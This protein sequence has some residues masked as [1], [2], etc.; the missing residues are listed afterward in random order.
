M[1]P[2]PIL[3]LGDSPDLHTGLG[4]I[5]RDLAV[6]TSSLPEFRVG[7]LGRGG[8]G[9][10][11]FPIAQYTYCECG[12][13]GQ[14]NIEQV[15]ND[16]AGEEWGIIMSV[17][18]PSRLLWFVHPNGMPKNTIDFLQ[19]GRF[20]RW[21]YFAVDSVGVGGKLTTATRSTIAGYDRPLGYGMWGAQVISESI[22]REV[23]WMPHGMN[24]DRWVR[25]DRDAARMSMGFQKG[26]T[27][28]GMIATNQA[29][30][31]W[32]L[33][34]STIS[35]LRHRHKNLK[36]WLHTD[37]MSRSHAWNIDSL[38]HDFGLQDHVKVTLSG[39]FTDTQ[40][41]YAYTACD[42]TMLASTGEGF[43]YP[44]VESLACGT[45][46]VHGNYGGGAEL[47]PSANWLVEPQ[48]WRLEGIHNCVRPVYN[49]QDW[50]TTIE[51]VMDEKV[52][53]DF[54][55]QATS[56]LDWSIL[57]PACWQKWM[58]AGVPA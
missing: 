39:G 36:F 54:C 3:F 14:G 21:G 18:D 34:F 49:P 50:A 10:R 41:S 6:L 19:S 7:Y 43:G 27:W 26:E 29:R 24:L 45:P 2:T 5:G 13:W 47:V 23:D 56:H 11:K 4:R 1:K 58:K 48:A 16:F 51:R 12:Q 52:S 28:V 38:V 40:L 9:S 15:W 22:G 31:D 33:A 32:G 37:V 20:A 57:W 25:R 35:E 8:T 44:I 46:V 17:W 30:K 53:P 42:V 55:R